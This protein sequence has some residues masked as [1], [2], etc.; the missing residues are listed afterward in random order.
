MLIW[1]FNFLLYLDIRDMK[2]EKESNITKAP[3]KTISV[4]LFNAVDLTE[5][6][7]I[8]TFLVLEVGIW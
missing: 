7:Y 8:A 2:N 3:Y 4:L 5:A 1:P 6:E